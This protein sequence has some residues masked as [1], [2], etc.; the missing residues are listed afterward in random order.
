MSKK[1]F[2]QLERYRKEKKLSILA[3]CRE[4]NTHNVNYH[5]WKKS[6][7][8][9]GPYKRIV[10]EF[11]ESRTQPQNI[12]RTPIQLT[13]NNPEIAV[14]GV[15]CVYPGA[16]NVKELWENILARR[17]QFRRMLD[18]RLPLSEYY[19]ADPKAGDKIY[20]PKAALIDGFSFEWSKWRI[21]K[22]TFESTDIVHWL[23]LD[24]AVKTFEDAGYALDAIPNQ[25]TG[26]ILGNTL[27]GEQTRSQTLRIRWPYVKKT[28][29]STLSA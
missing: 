4:L 8:I 15:A 26:V 7:S 16:S 28:L 10:E 9:S 3:L 20:Q 1:L 24:T 2:D 25:N 18:T 13:T 19:D 6:K 11:L 12:P 23:A 14:I 22:K 29:Q 27:T 5:R 21:P 17:V